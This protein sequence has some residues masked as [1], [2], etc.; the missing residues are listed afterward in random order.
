[1]ESISL[2]ENAS[3]ASIRRAELAQRLVESCPPALADEIALVG[4]TARGIADD[5]FDLELNLWAQAIPPL[6][7]A[8]RVADRGGRDRH[9]GRGNAAPRSIAV[10]FRASSIP[11]R[12]R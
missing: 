7:S 9:S 2:P 12:W 8:C 5:E 10:D 6:E 11:F 1:M 3:A 4:S